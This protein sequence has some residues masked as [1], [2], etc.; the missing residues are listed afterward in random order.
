MSREWTDEQ[1]QAIGEAQEP[2][3]NILV[4]A[5]AGSGKTAVLTER[6]IRILK[7]HI[8]INKL[9]VLT[10]TNAAAAEMKE[11][12]GKVAPNGDMVTVCTF[13]SFCARMLRTY[14]SFIPG[15]KENFTIFSDTD[16]SKIFKDIFKELN[17]TKLIYL[18]KTNS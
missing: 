2:L 4:S 5:G 9:L 10:F 18:I 15:Y 1:K 6:V 17:M 3:Q 8:D 11:R 7:D 12:I 13:H 14:A 16:T